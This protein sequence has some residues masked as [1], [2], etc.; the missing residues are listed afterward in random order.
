MKPAVEGKRFSAIM[1]ADVVGYS[2]LMSMDVESTVGMLKE[3][4]QIFS[5]LIT[6]RNGWVV[7]APGDSI[8]AEFAT[9]ED[10]VNSAVEIQAQVENSMP[11]C[12]RTNEGS[13]AS[14]SVRGRCLARRMAFTATR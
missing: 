4:R 1:M 3:C 11:R 2:R 12:P 8:L 7:N 5:G 13:S 6:G 14:A 9:A 10:A